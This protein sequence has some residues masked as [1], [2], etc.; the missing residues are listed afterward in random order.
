MK[1]IITYEDGEWTFEVVS[2]GDEDTYYEQFSIS[3]L[4]DAQDAAWDLMEELATRNDPIAD[5]F[6]DLF[7]DNE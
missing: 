1:A 7:D 5:A 2:T 4:V 6:G 3:D